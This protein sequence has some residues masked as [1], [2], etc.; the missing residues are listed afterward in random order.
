MNGSRA[1][2]L[3]ARTEVLQ[4]APN[5][6]RRHLLVAAAL[7]EVLAGPIIVGG[8]AEEYWTPDEYGETDLDLCVSLHREDVRT[9]TDLGFE[10][11][12]G[13]RHWYHAATRVAVEFPDSRIEGDEDRTV[14]ED[15]GDGGKAEVIGLDDLYLD[16]VRQA[17]IND[18]TEGRE[19]KSAL[20]VASANFDR[21]DWD[22]IRRVMRET[23]LRLGDAM[24]RV[25]SRIGRRIRRLLSDPGPRA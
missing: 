3:L 25:N 13:R 2:K 20:A 19:F 23:D 15:V 12:R 11:E 10:L 21:I 8:T 24:K 16:R 22:Y 1:K 17:T 5:R 6:L 14:L 7:R 18:A 9:L 4:G